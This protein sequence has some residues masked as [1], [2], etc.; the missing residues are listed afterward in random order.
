MTVVRY[1]CQCLPLIVAVVVALLGCD[2]PSAS[3]ELTA[4]ADEPSPRFRNVD[5]P[6]SYVGDASCTTCHAREAAVYGQHAMSQTF[7]PWTRATRIEP[8]SYIRTST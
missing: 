6:T 4:L 7:H 2:R 5:T 8:P 1:A 3:P